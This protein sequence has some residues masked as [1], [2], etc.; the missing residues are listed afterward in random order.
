MKNPFKKENF[1]SAESKSNS[2][3]K[4]NTEQLSQKTQKKSREDLEK[5]YSELSKKYE[6][7]P[8]EETR[9]KLMAVYNRLTEQK[10]PMQPKQTSVINDGVL[11][12]AR[13]IASD[14]GKNFDELSEDKQNKLIEKADV[15]LQGAE[16][17]KSLMNEPEEDSELETLRNENQNL[18][19][20]LIQTNN[21]LGDMQRQLVDLNN[22]ITEKESE[23]ESLRLALHVTELQEPNTEQIEQPNI[24][25]DSQIAYQMLQKRKEKQPNTKPKQPYQLENLELY[26]LSCKHTIQ[27]HSRGGQ[28]NGCSCGC[29]RTIEDIAKENK[30]PLL[31]KSNYKKIHNGTKHE[32]FMSRNFLPKKETMLESIEDIPLSPSILKQANALQSMVSPKI[33]K[34]A[35]QLQKN[36]Q[37]QLKQENKRKK[38]L[39]PVSPD[40]CTCGHMMDNHFESSAFCTEMDCP[41]DQFR[42]YPQ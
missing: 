27:A 37:Q 40:A 36:T 1:Q 26:C 3:I 23:I 24:Q 18:Q 2:Q 4:P 22:I 17:L 14:F 10:N 30:I 29:L 11:D 15:E 38:D 32:S 41:C 13:E 7:D 12:R 39:E 42:A 16:M 20:Q 21:T 9:K 31:T 8:S 28:S 19:D 6:K 35:Q 34:R 33:E 5:M 25:S